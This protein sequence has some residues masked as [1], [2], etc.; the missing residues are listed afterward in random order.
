[1]TAQPSAIDAGAGERRY[2]RRVVL[3]MAAALI[4]IAGLWCRWPG[5]GLPWPIAKW[6]GSIL[7]GA[8][9][10]F[11]AALLR[12]NATLSWN[13][14]L[15]IAIALMVEYSRLWHPSWLDEFRTT[16]AGLVLLGRLFS[17]WNILAYLAAI[18]VGA[19]IDEKWLRALSTS[20]RA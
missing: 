7:W 18:C 13:L 14:A 3:T 16:S 9:V 4:I 1:M 11:L 19:I 6:G 17:Y 2:P 8:M 15:A 10:Y 5:S 12:P 20:R